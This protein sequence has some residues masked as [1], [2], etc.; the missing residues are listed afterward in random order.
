MNDLAGT[1]FVCLLTVSF[2]F[3]E[4]KQTTPITNGKKAKYLYLREEVP[5]QASY[6]Q[7]IVF[8]L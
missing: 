5:G 6:P 1:L 7:Q 2:I 4:M 3:V 8:S